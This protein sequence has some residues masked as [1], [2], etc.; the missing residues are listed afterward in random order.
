MELKFYINDALIEEPIG[1]DSFKSV[2]ERT[3]NHGVSAE[4]SFGTLEFYGIAFQIIQ[5]AYHTDIDSELIFKAELKCS[6]DGVWSEIYKGVIDLSSYDENKSDY[7]SVKCK[8]GEVGVRTTF[9]NRADTQV[10]LNS[11]KSMDG[12]DLPVYSY[13]D[14]E[15]EI[16]SKDIVCSD[17]CKMITTGTSVNLGTLYKNGEFAARPALNWI[18]LPF[19]TE[20]NELFE[21]FSSQYEMHW[22]S[23]M[24][25]YNSALEN[26]TPTVESI[27][28]PNVRV[29]G[30]C[31]LTYQIHINNAG[32]ST[33]TPYVLLHSPNSSGV[34]EW[35]ELYRGTA[36]NSFTYNSELIDVEFNFSAFCNKGSRI[37]F[38]LLLNSAYM[39]G[40]NF[41]GDVNIVIP[42][43]NDS[44]LN[45]QALTHVKSS[46]AKVSLVHECFSRISEI[47]SGLT[48][49]SDWYARGNSNVNA[50]GAIRDMGQGSLKCITTGLKLRNAVLT[51]GS[52]PYLF[53]SFKELFNSLKAIDAVGWGFS[54]EDGVEYIR[55]E[56]FDWFYKD[57]II[58]D[59]DDVREISRKFDVKDAI[60]RLKIGYAKFSEIKDINAI[61]TFHTER[62]YSRKI[63][64]IDKQ[65]EQLCKFIAD[66]YA[67]E[68]TRRKS[69]DKTTEDW[70]YDN[71]IFI[72]TMKFG[73]DVNRVYHFEIDTGMAS[74]HG[75]VISP[76][77][78]INVR[79]TPARNARRWAQRLF[80]ITSTKDT[81]EF[82][83]G[84]GNISALGQPISASE[85]KYCEDYYG[86]LGEKDNI[87]F[88]SPILKSEVIKFDYPI[89]ISEYQLIKS[90]PYDIIKV[91][92][93]NCYLKKVEYSHMRGIASFEL[94]PAA[95]Q[96]E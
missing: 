16:P 3:E 38:A 58:L 89:S 15:I 4:V 62:Q 40:T 17:K 51:N 56:P 48:V 20:M 68:Y 81:F 27:K 92:G 54:V 93:E 70:T 32:S 69:F 84:T 74:T 24:Q 95:N 82:M 60:T 8:V 30:S 47:I 50:V 53:L 64:S 12:V 66:P 86:V 78:M 87:S 1:F 6:D 59:I 31:R 41:N 85:W 76:E 63:K 49:K 2:I 42:D 52:E 22:I 75:S 88:V 25:D 39:S 19:L 28:H 61:D 55:V 45:M 80:E 79:I 43:E 73:P 46:R 83:S 29:I 37:Y 35:T 72:L 71:D 11:L 7:C 90:N 77:T 9:N 5:K 10:Y 57:E 23:N 14:K 26:K 91:N 67:I 21:N 34:Y 13:L 94:I 96:D 18:V 33:V 36:S 44:Y 65:G